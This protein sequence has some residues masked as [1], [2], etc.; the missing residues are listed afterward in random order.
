MLRLAALLHDIGK[1]ATRRFE[2][3]GGVS[4]HHHEVVGAKLAAKRLKALRFDK[5]DGQGR[6]PAGRAA[7]ALPRVRRGPVDRLGGAPLRHR[8]RAA[9][10]AAAPAD[11]RRTAR[12]ATRARPRGCRA[13]TTTSRRGSTRCQEQEELAKVRPELDGNE[14]AEV[15]GIRPGPVLGRAYKFLLER[16]A[17]PGPGRPRGRRGGAAP[18]VGAAARV[19]STGSSVMSVFGGRPTLL[20]HRG[21]GRGVSTGSP[22]TPSSRSSPRRRRVCAGSS[23]TSAG[24]ATTPSW[25]A[26]TRASPTRAARPTASSPTSPS[27]R[28]ATSAQ[29]TL[30]SVLAGLPRGHRRQP[31]PQDVDGG[32]AA[33]AGRATTAALLAQVV[34]VRGRPAARARLVLRPRGAAPGRGGRARHTPLPAHLADLP[35]AQG[36]PRRRPPGCRGGRRPLVTSF[37]PNAAD[38]RTGLPDR[39]VCRGGGPRGRPGGG[40]LVPRRAWLATCSR[41]AWTRWSW[42]TRHERSRRCAAWPTEGARAPVLVLLHAV[43]PVVDPVP[44]AALV[45]G[46]LL[47]HDHVVPAWIAVTWVSV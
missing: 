15:L 23:S 6:G 1:P 16:A 5:D 33:Q 11:P 12:P 36:D 43:G 27:R 10:A 29:C 20:G 45:V 2:A 21:M 34:T 19:P 13:P 47:D 17:G 14:I 26:T 41:R 37:G 32:R 31:R 7:P 25:S 35:A 18:V 40:R 44:V 38:Q 30:E 42:T 22:R 39:G 8:R 46:A 24:P 4:F 9:A 28:P 3:G